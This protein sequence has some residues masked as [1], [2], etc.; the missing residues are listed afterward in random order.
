MPAIGS[1]IDSN[2][3]Q[4]LEKIFAILLSRMETGNVSL[5]GFASG[6]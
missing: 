4:A 5:H 3:E 6:G 1:G 2:E